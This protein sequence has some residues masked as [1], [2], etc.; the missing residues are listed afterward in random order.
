MTDI[1][2]SGL[3]LRTHDA[4]YPADGI[5]PYAHQ[6]RVRELFADEAE[7]L[8][9]NDS[10]TGGGKTLSWLAPV[11]EQGLHTIALYPTNALI[12]DQ[13]QSIEE[14]LTDHFDREPTVLAITAET[15]REDHADRFDYL[16]S[17]VELIRD[18]LAEQ[19]QRGNHVIL[20]TNPD[21][22]VMLRRELYGRDVNVRLGEFEVAV[23]DEFHRAGLKEQNT[24]LFLF[25]ELFDRPTEIS[26]LSKLVF[27][28][29]TPTDRLDQRFETAMSATYHRVTDRSGAERRAFDAPP[30]TDGWRPVMPPVDLDV[31]S[32]ATFGTAGELLGDQLAE[33]LDF[34]AG[35]RTVVM[36]DG[37]HEVERVYSELADA[38]PERRIER[39]DG[40]HRGDIDAKLNRFDVLVSNSAV[41]VGIDFDTDRIL[42]SGH[43]RASFLQRLGR[44][45][46]RD[47]VSKA[48]CY[49]P[50]HV[51]DSLT[52]QL[53]EPAIDSA[54]RPATGRYT[55]EELRT[56]LDEAYPS[57]R[58]PESFERR[59]A[60]T[61]AMTH[62]GD[63]LDATTEDKRPTV[64]SES[65]TRVAQHFLAPESTRTIADI[66]RLGET[67]SCPV[68]RKLQSYRGDSIQALV[69]N[70]PDDEL[71]AYDLLYLLRYGRVTFY[72]R[73]EFEQKV[74]AE[75]RERVG[76]YA[77]F[78]DGFCVFDGTIET[79]EEGY[80]R[81]VVFRPTE[82][83]HDWLDT[84]QDRTSR[85]PRVLKSIGID[86]SSDEHPRVEGI[87]TLRDRLDALGERGGI[88]CY[89]LE[90]TS[91]QIKS[92]YGLDD[93]FF[94]YPLSMPS[95]DR[96]C[97]AFGTD[98]LYLHCHVQDRHAD[99]NDDEDGE[100]IGLCDSEVGE[101]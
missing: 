20:L 53:G 91:E 74:P 70:R 40:F 4:E 71:R 73:Q 25:D 79:T 88:L 9:V 92:L 101:S 68:R 96:Y 51:L 27:L 1:P 3:A 38:L 63:R 19:F 45:R 43:D 37:I 50:R 16:D 75:A 84:E 32:S 33:T 22:F 69:Y 30:L 21:I 77:S 7:F 48:R 23:A 39:I 87:E 100:F 54:S 42:F 36:L 86:A 57:P 62:V 10:P 64:A 11:V 17:N 80:G 82:Y 14:L 97:L 8:A 46:T 90:G 98:A 60:A 29:A 89:P 26:A 78:V 83:L 6:R 41:E 55:R 31:R 2:L 85:M 59:Y 5:V 65:E 24:L 44:L 15:L 47:E 35:G 99:D 34:C 94:L 18:L 67:V 76:S 58:Q 95:G 13:K 52:D 12:E 49:V 56:V 81:T 28:S 93:F 66:K 61:E 72:D